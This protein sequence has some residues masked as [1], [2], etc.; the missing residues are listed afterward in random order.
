[1]K[2]FLKQDVEKIGIAGEIIT[3]SDGY[4]KNFL[5]PRALAV[6]ITADNEQ[7]YRAR[8]KTVANRQEAVATKTSMLAEKIKGLK[9]TIARKMHDGEKLYGSIAEGE[10]VDLLA[11]EGISIG[12]SQVLFEKAIKSK[13]VYPVTIKLS[14]SLQPQLQL[15]V[16][17]AAQ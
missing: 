6:E 8:Q 2:V 14:N 5:L 9:L 3:V 11:Q 7:F 10:I 4:G 12:K 1:M 15:K 17:E 16:I 13:G